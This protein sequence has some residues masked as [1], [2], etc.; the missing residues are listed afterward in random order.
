MSSASA[1][2]E[3]FISNYEDNYD[4]DVPEKLRAIFT[5]QV[6]AFTYIMRSFNTS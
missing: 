2:L 4:E 3:Y 1:E 6:F 5:N